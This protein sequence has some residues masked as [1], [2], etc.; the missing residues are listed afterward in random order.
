MKW[1]RTLKSFQ[2]FKIKLKT[3]KPISVDVLFKAYLIVSPHAD[4]SL[5]DG[6]FK[7]DLSTLY[8]ISE[9]YFF[10]EIIISYICFPEVRPETNFLTHN[11]KTCL[12]QF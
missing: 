6:T 9:V 3:Q 12:V 10:W 7:V 2:I 4:L 11:T 1:L 5:P 8:S